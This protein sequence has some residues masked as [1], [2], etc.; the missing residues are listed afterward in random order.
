MM[1]IANTRDA[2]GQ[3]LFSGYHTNTQA[4]S[5]NVDGSFNYDGDR[6]K[7]SLQI[8]ESMNV[9]TS[10]DGGTA[11]QT[12]DTGAGRKSVFD[13]ITNTINTINNSNALSNQ[14]SAR[15]T[16]AVDF[17]V[18]RDPQDWTFVISGGVGATTI[19]TTISDGNYDDVVTKINAATSS[20]GVQASLDSATGRITLTDTQSRIIK[21]SDIEIEGTDFATD[22]IDSYLD[23]NTLEGSGAI[24]GSSRRLTDTDQLIT[25]SVGEV[26]KATDHLSLQRSF[27]GAQLNKA[28]LQKESIDQ[29][30]IAT[31]ERVSDL[32]DADL[33]AIVTQ[34]QSLLINRDAAQ[35]AYAK[36]SQ[37]SLFDFIK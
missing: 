27:L 5:K 20:T 36:I 7:H 1:E 11:F 28:E 4:F 14:A 13:I 8:S 34:I 18:P 21:I 31:S 2:Q 9:A 33:A 32:G 17:N 6:G 3:S 37:N 24:V 15:A 10:I 30:I 23:F 25:R 22:N 35:Q 16:A 29:R 19:T 12:V 26:K